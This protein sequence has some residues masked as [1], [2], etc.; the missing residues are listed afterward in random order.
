M[1]AFDVTFT[2][3][4]TQVIIIPLEASPSFF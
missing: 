1:L 4:S 2:N 3:P